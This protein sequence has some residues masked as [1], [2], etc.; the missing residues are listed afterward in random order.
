MKKIILICVLYSCCLHGSEIPRRVIAFWDSSHETVEDS[1]VANTFEMVLNHLGLDILYYDFAKPLPNLSAQKDISAIILCQQPESNAD[2]PEDFIDWIMAAINKGIKVILMRNP[3]FLGASLE[4]Q[5]ELYEKFG[6]INQGRNVPFTF[7]YRIQFQDSQLIPFEKNYPAILPPFN[8]TQ[9]NGEVAKSYLTVAS[10]ENR[11][12]TSDLIII[13]RVGAYVN[14]YYESNFDFHLLTENP[15]SLGWYINPFIFF[16]IA[17]D[18]PNF[19]IPDTTTLAGRRIFYSICHGDAWNIETSLEEFQQ[20]EETYASKVLLEKVIRPNPDVPIGVGIIAA[21]ID[22]AWVAKSKSQDVAKEYLR[23]PQV[24]NASHTYSHP[25]DWAFFAPGQHEREAELNILYKYRYPTWQ[26]SYISWAHAMYTKYTNPQLYERG[27]YKQEFNVGYATPRA[28]ANHPF[29]LEKEIVGSTEF[30]NQFAPINNLVQ[31]LLWSG[32]GLVWGEGLEFCY[33]IGIKN[34]GVGST[35]F[36]NENPSYI[37][38]GPIG[39]KP[40]GWLQIYNSSN[41]ENDYTYEW[42]KDFFRFHL[43]QETLKNTNEPIRVKP[44]CLYYHSYSGEF[45]ASVNAILSNLD[46]I[47]SQSPIPIFPSR[48]CEI[49]TGFYTAAIEPLGDSKWIIRNRAGLQ[50][51]RLDSASN[52]QVD[53]AQSLGIVGYTTYQNS[54]YI[55]LDAAVAEPIVSIKNINQNNNSPYLIDSNWEIWNLKVQKNGW[56][57]NTKGWG[58]LQMN[59]FVPQSGTY[60]IAASVLGKR[61]EIQAVAEKNLL[62]VELELPFNVVTEIEVTKI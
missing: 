47:K 38:V 25:F 54:L 27:H 43:L 14:P 8:V 51:V 15:Q 50:T 57:F 53:L 55:Y 23:T 41:G 62:T 35:R 28:Y 11:Q 26:N 40:D 56:H 22:P 30:I 61:A 31:A 7:D 48:F 34:L 29:N 36:D 3:G 44:I 58:T 32:D 42:E 24:E 19:P 21:D 1:I 12:E 37:F 59:W 13:N 6:F 17:L 45:Q 60:F 4:K 2:D 20:E 49:G 10:V 52:K 16:K 9:L 39:R 46:Y 33:Q 18:L 5:N